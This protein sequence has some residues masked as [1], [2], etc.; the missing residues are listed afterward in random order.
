MHFS[1]MRTACFS[2][3]L[4]CHACL[5]PHHAH[6]PTMHV[7]SAIHAHLCYAHPLTYMPPCHTC[8]LPRTPLFH[9]CPPPTWTEGMT[10]ACENITL[11][12]TSFAGG[13]H[14]QV[15]PVF[16]HWRDFKFCTSIFLDELIKLLLFLIDVT[17]IM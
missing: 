12:Q 2:V 11:P 17:R 10:H 6:P 8:P 14:N 1:R 16:F 4:S 9:T 3:R 15:Y 13:N 7:P 5:H